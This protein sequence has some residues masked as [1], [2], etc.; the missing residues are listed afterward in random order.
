MPAGG[1]REAKPLEYMGSFMVTCYDLTGV[2]ASGAL[3]G[4]DGVAVDPGVIPLGTRIFIDGVGLRVAD[5]TGQ[6][7]I[8]AHVDIWEPTYSQCAE[9]GVQQRG[10]YRASP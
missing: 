2:T 7:I 4:P 1:A 6:D 3:A 10:V 8:G 9:W 5:D